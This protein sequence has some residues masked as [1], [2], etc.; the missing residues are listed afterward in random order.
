MSEFDCVNRP[1]PS[2]ILGLELRLKYVLLSGE[3]GVVF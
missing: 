3:V 1:A 2:K